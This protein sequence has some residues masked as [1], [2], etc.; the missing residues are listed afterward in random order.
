MFYTI[1]KINNDKQL[2]LS[3]KFN[4]LLTINNKGL[5]SQYE[6]IEYIKTIEVKKANIDANFDNV[7]SSNNVALYPKSD[8]QYQVDDFNSRKGNKNK[9]EVKQKLKDILANQVLNTKLNRIRL[10]LPSKQ[11]IRIDGFINFD[12]FKVFINSRNIEDKSMSITKIICVDYFKPRTNKSKYIFTY[13][14]DRSYQEIKSKYASPILPSELKFNNILSPKTTRIYNN[15]NYINIR[16]TKRDL[17]LMN[18]RISHVQNL[19]ELELKEFKTSLLDKKNELQKERAKVKSLERKEQKK[20]E[21]LE[22]QR[23]EYLLTKDL[24]KKGIKHLRCM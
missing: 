21:K 5:T 18:V 17:K 8:Y 11:V 7:G 2:Q 12:G 22:L 4:S 1:E 24:P 9:L 13:K 19:T 14:T 6:I 3:N 20:I 10:K 23:K 15:D 16:I